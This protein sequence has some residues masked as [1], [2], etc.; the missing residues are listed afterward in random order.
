[1]KWRPGTFI[2]AL[3][4][5]LGA[6]SD[7]ACEGKHDLISVENNAAPGLVSV[8]RMNDPNASAQL[9]SG[10]Y[11]VENNAWRWTAG[12]FSVVLGVPSRAA[13][14]GATLTLAFTIPDG[15]MEKLGNV[16]LTASVMGAALKPAKYEKP[17]PDAYT[18]NIPASLLAG[19]SIRIDFALDKSVPPGVDKRE[20]GIMASSVGLTSN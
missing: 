17:G 7:A 5:A 2:F 16:T 20:L 11:M 3:V 4:I 19:D 12:K 14:S 13:R 18:A 1:M 6:L 8:L 9:L 15:V 10:F